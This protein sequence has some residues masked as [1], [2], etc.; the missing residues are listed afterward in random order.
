MGQ[1][2]S[3]SGPSF[4]GKTY[5]VSRLIGDLPDLKVVYFEKHFNKKN[6]VKSYEDFYKDVDNIRDLGYNVICESVYCPEKN[7]VLQR[8][9]DNSTNIVCLPSLSQH[10]ENYRK[11]LRLHGWEVVKKRSGGMSIETMAKNYKENMPRPDR[12]VRYD[13]HNYSQILSYI[14]GEICG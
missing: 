11:F 10:T 12:S 3:I 9:F 1:V 4:S 7:P 13:C 6:V 5:L 8:C 14:R 2:I